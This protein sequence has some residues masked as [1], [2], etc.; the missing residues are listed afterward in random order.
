MDTKASMIRMLTQM[1][2]SL[3]ST[4][5]NMATPCSVNANGQTVECLRFLNRSQFVTSSSVSYLLN[6]NLKCSGK[7]S[8][9][10]LTLWFKTFVSTPYK[11]ARSLSKITWTPRIGNILFSTEDNWSQ[12]ATSSPPLVIMFFSSTIIFLL[13]GYLLYLNSATLINEPTLKRGI[14]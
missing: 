11:S 5:A 13:R 9:L 14:F 6:W 12:F 10:R 2:V 8:I 7:R 4:E 1:A 3:L